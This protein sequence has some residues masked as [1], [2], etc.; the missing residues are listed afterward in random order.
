MFITKMKVITINALVGKGEM[1]SE[2]IITSSAEEALETIE[3][4]LRGDAPRPTPAEERLQSLRA[5][6]TGKTPEEFSRN[7]AK[8]PLEAVEFL[9][10]RNFQNPLQKAMQKAEA[11]LNPSTT[12]L[13]FIQLAKYGV[14]KTSADAQRAVTYL[15]LTTAAR[16]RHLNLVQFLVETRDCTAAM[17][18]ALLA[19]VTNNDL[20]MARYLLEKGALQT[21]GILGVAARNNQLEMIQLLL[22]YG[23]NAWHCGQSA[24]NG[25]DHLELRKFF[26]RKLAGMDAQ[27]PT[28]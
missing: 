5:F 9:A 23:A 24:A 25:G 16:Y 19:A 13:T 18:G 27:L 3:T 26:S 17:T 10:A 15:A 6:L 28:K 4:R 2:P 20:T 21:G 7:C 12:K 14:V 8:Y 1:N 22:D 11:Y